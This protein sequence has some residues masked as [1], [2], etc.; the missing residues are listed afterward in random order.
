MLKQLEMYGEGGTS[1]K[2]LVEAHF[3]MSS[4]NA[5]DIPT[6]RAPYFEWEIVDPGMPEAR[7]Q[8]SMGRIE[9]G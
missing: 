3:F 9:M 4:L 6:D 2:C 1:L 8:L 7:W 5:G